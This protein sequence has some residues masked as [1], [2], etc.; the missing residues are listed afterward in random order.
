M[1]E[2][3]FDSNKKNRNTYW[4]DATA[5]EM[6]NVKVTLMILHNSK[7]A[8]NGYQF[9]NYQIVFDVKMEHFRRKACLVVGGHVTQIPEFI[10]NSNVVTRE[11][12]ALC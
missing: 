3:A 4:Q 11:T 5:K 10:T 9:I 1:V 7:E 2:V 6:E 8:P 12:V